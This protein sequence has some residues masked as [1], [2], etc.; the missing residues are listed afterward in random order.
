MD[1]DDAPRAGRWAGTAKKLQ[2]QPIAAG[3]TN[4]NFR[5][6]VDGKPLL[7]PAAR[8]V[9]RAAR[10]RPRERAAQHA[11]RREGRG[12][13]EGASHHDARD[14]RRSLLEWLAGPDD[15]ERGV[16]GAGHARANR[17]GP[18]AAPRR[19]ALPRRLQHVP[20]DRVLPARRRRA[21][22]PDPG[23]LPRRSCRRSRSSRRPSPRGRSPTVPC[24][25]DLLAENYLDDGARLWI[26]DYEYSGNNDPTFELGNTAQELGFDAARQEE[27]CAAYFGEATPALARPDAAA[28]DHVRR[29]L[30]AV[31]RH[32]GRDLL[33]RLRLLG[34]GRGAL[35]PRVGGLRRATTSTTSSPRPIGG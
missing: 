18:P 34:L 32:P 19:P 25:N 26:V 10:R 13:P 11:G 3:L 15:V 28:D 21:L 35:G 23:R 12:R 29:R 17:R 9:D 24:H 7:R 22:D 5:V 31:G 6:E 30:D 4:Q 20:A 27:L 2:L 8:A 33:D 16:P 1:V 14:R